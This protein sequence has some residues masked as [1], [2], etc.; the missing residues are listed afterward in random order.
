MKNFTI[1]KINLVSTLDIQISLF[2]KLW[3]EQDL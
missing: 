3:S 1:F 2:W